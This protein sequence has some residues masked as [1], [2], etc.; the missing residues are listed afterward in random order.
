MCPED[1]SLN[2]IVA[3]LVSDDAIY[4]QSRSWNAA[5]EHNPLSPHWILI[6]SLWAEDLNQ[7]FGFH[8]STH[9]TPAA[10]PSRSCKLPVFPPVCLVLTASWIEWLTACREDC[11][12]SPEDRFS[13]GGSVSLYLSLTYPSLNQLCRAVVLLSLVELRVKQLSLAGEEQLQAHSHLN[14]IYNIYYLHQN[15]LVSLC[16]WF[17]AWVVYVL[18]YSTLSY[19]VP[20]FQ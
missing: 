15:T 4:F 19:L 17:L 6:V 1:G 14:L 18:F 13:G 8:I 9:V 5:I 11:A 10:S 16:S 20:L 12:L 3:V 7:W 2:Y